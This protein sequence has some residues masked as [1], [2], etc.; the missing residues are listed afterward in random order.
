MP[1]EGKTVLITGASEGMG[2]SVARQLAEKGASVI[3]V[4]RSANKL[5][6]AM[7]EAKFFRT[8][9]GRRPQ[10]ADPAIPLSHR[11][12]LQAR[13]RQLPSRRCNRLEQRQASRHRV[14]PRRQVDARLLG[15]G[16]AVALAGAHG[17]QL[18]G[19][20]RDGPRHHTPMVR[21]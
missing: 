11:R 6:E 14:V 3:L 15:R 19:Q 1:V 16:P 9:T 12:C 8:V 17:P 10:P 7:A 20:R 13:L 18:L 4:S 21:A 2:R 5:E